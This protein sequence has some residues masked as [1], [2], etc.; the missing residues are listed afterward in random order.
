MEEIRIKIT[1]CKVICLDEMD[2]N[3]VST[4]PKYMRPKDKEKLLKLVEEKMKLDD[5]IIQEQFNKVV[6]NSVLNE[7][8]DYSSYPTY[9]DNRFKDQQQ[10]IDNEADDISAELSKPPRMDIA[11]NIL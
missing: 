2:L 1:K 3:P 4:N 5:S 9:I 11:G 8:S 10:K 6:L 7:K